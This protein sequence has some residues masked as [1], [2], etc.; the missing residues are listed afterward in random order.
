LAMRAGLAT[1]KIL[2]MPGFFEDLEHKTENFLKPIRESASHCTI[3]SCGSMFTIFFGVDKVDS[4][5]D[6]KALD[7]VRFKRFF[8]YLFDRGVYLSPSAY[9]ANFISAAHTE[10]NLKKVQECILDYF[11]VEKNFSENSRTFSISTS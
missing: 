3:Q 9:E 4:K 10:E 1:L 11:L 8:H 6:L 7:V 2:E 5:E